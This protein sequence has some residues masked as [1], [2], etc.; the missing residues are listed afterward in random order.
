MSDITKIAK[1][2]KSNEEGSFF[3]RRRD[4]KQLPNKEDP[5]I[6]W[7]ETFYLN[8]LL[9]HFEYQIEVSI[10]TRKQETESRN[11]KF[12]SMFPNKYT[13]SQIK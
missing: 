5:E 3:V 7:E 8:V 1:Q 12:F 11:C 4:G 10:R 6:N 13:Q 2:K 9:H